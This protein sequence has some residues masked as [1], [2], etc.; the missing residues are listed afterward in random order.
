MIADSL[1]W[2]GFATSANDAR[3]KRYSAVLSRVHRANIRARRAATADL[4]PAPVAIPPDVGHAA[5]PHGAL[6]DTAPVV[7][8]VRRM[9]VTLDERKGLRP[10]EKTYLR[11]DALTGLEPDH[12]IARYACSEAM[13]AAAADYLG[14][15]PILFGMFVLRSPAVAGPPSG[16]QLFHCDWEDVRQFKVFVHCSEVGPANGPLVGVR[17]SASAEVKRAVRYRYG[18]AHFR[19]H[20]EE[21]LP[22]LGHDDR[23][24]F[25]GPPGAVTL[26]DTSSCLHYGSRCESGTEPRLV[27]QLQY[28]SPAAFA[29]VGARRQP[30]PV[31]TGPGTSPVQAMLLSH[32]PPG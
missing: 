14:M 32:R 1:R 12:P 20:D 25:E 29:W 10:G 5:D 21:V 24:S 15:V 19:L 16:S 7:E 11:D 2:F 9:A 4:S 28:L 27:L 6:G 26:I 13:I 3:R 8:E 18:G 17:A 22:R 23:S 30:A 31:R